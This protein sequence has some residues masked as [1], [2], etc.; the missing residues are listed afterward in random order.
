MNAMVK[1]TLEDI[2]AQ[3]QRVSNLAR[4]GGLT[5]AEFSNAIQASAIGEEFRENALEERRKLRGMIG[6]LIA[7]WSTPDAKIRNAIELERAE[8]ARVDELEELLRAAQNRLSAAQMRRVGLE[9]GS[10]SRLE[11]ARN[12]LERTADPVIS[13]FV[14]TLEAEVDVLHSGQG[15]GRYVR[16]DGRVPKGLPWGLQKMIAEGVVPSAEE[17]E[18][19]SSHMEGLRTAIAAA[20]RLQETAL[21]GEPLRQALA[22]IE[23]EIPHRDPTRSVQGAGIRKRQFLVAVTK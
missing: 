3:L 13:M 23:A 9:H 20:L 8:R 14:E 22:A 17:H 18:R 4:I 10:Q 16:G 2:G 7:S 12:L 15:A 19:L 5:P 11:G 1:V 21:D 6:D